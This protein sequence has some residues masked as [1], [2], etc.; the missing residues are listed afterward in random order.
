LHSVIPATGRIFGALVAIVRSPGRLRPPWGLRVSRVM[1][2]WWVGFIS[3]Y[4]GNVVYGLGALV[5]A[6]QPL[7]AQALLRALLL[8]RL[9][10]HDAR[11]GVLVLLLAAMLVLTGLLSE[12]HVRGSNGGAPEGGQPPFDVSVL[13]QVAPGEFV[14][15]GHDLRWVLGRLL[16]RDRPRVSVV[17]G[18]PGQGKTE[19]VGQALLDPRVHRRYGDGI[20]VIQCLTYKSSSIVLQTALSRFDPQR[21]W[22]PAENL[23][24]LQAVAHRLLDQRRALI[25]LDSLGPELAN[26]E[27]AIAELVRVLA[28]TG[29]ALIFTA[30]QELPGVVLDSQYKL[31]DLASDEALDLFGKVYGAQVGTLTPDDLRIVRHMAVDRLGCLPLAIKLVAS[32]AIPRDLREFADELNDQMR[33]LQIVSPIELALRLSAASLPPAARR[34]F[35]ALGAF[36]SEEFSRKAALSLASA[37]GVEDP[38]AML[39]VLV[40]RTLVS[41]FPR[42]DMPDGS[43]HE[44]VRLHTVV[45]D[46]ALKELRAWPSHDVQTARRAIAAYYGDYSGRVTLAALTFDR[47][48]I[49]GALDWAHAE[50]E[51]DLLMRLC[52]GTCLLWFYQGHTSEC[53]KYLPWGIEAAERLADRTQDRGY[54]LTALDLRIYYA[55]TLRHMGRIG[56][57]EGELRAIVTVSERLGEARRSAP[58]LTFLGQLALMR[59]RPDEAE[60]QYRDARAVYAREHDTRRQGELLGY[61]G[62]VAQRKGDYDRAEE[63]Y[64]QALSAL[65]DAGDPRT[66]GAVLATLSQVLQKRGQLEKAT[67]VLQRAEVY[68]GQAPDRQTDGVMKAIRGQIAAQRGE[69]ER[70]QALLQESVEIAR[71]VG[72]I[73]EEG[74]GLVAMAHAEY[75]QVLAGRRGEVPPTASRL[76]VALEKL[77]VA[78]DSWDEGIALHHR[79]RVLHELGDDIGAEEALVQCRDIATR[80][81]DSRGQ[82]RALIS[83]AHLAYAQRR[84]QEAHELFGLAGRIADGLGERS[85]LSVV[86]TWQGVVAEA[87]GLDKQAWNYYEAALTPGGDTGLPLLCAGRFVLERRTRRAEGAAYLRGAIERFAR[88][89]MYSAER[90]AREVA[91][92]YRVSVP[93]WDLLR[94]EQREAAA[95]IATL[96]LDAAGMP[97]AAGRREVALGQEALYLPPPTGAVPDLPGIPVPTQ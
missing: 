46:Y 87:L 1:R 66:K 12:M 59:G 10:A 48:N 51:D 65:R 9:V 72:D 11:L 45:R 6:G 30:R 26:D 16:A 43:D 64:R 61:L 74:V 89:H 3:L 29:A 73:R 71:E 85:L 52:Y 58:V 77:H 60:R 40:R 96:S 55:H 21:T 94:E 76:T 53:A 34:F 91:R 49:G 15:R 19:L 62:Q 20:A 79:G 18:L 2:F 86:V 28:G 37:Q 25:V 70:A 84:L 44:R 80:F 68:L 22:S 75:E 82:C 63:Q 7:D 24:L 88:A 14:G 41:G 5:E 90:F 57:A 50:R 33:L 38:L 56:E 93:K 17:Y 42:V 54:R 78:E 47:V 92:R 81:D 69:F 8:E 27:Q 23:D 32:A 35:V 83:L 13:P 31:G 95:W 97:P 4:A 36:A 67:L 39:D